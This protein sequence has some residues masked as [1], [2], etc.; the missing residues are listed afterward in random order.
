MILRARA[1]LT[2]NRTISIGRSAKKK[3]LLSS[4]VTT[5]S[6][7]IRVE[8]EF[9]LAVVQAA[10]TTMTASETRQRL[11]PA[12][13]SAKGIPPP[14]TWETDSSSSSKTI[15]VP[16]SST[17]VAGNELTPLWTR[18]GLKAASSSQECSRR[19]TCP[20][21]PGSPKANSNSI[22][23]EHVSP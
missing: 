10:T 6:K 19:M 22:K 3:I 2:S 12:A 21:L 11:G 9:H 5:D 23:K 8:L 15:S 13:G 14:W 20:S 17:L 18:K 4:K 16:R 7:R 1:S